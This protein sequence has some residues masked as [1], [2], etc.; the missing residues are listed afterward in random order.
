MAQLYDGGGASARQRCDCYNSLRFA[1]YTVYSM[2]GSPNFALLAAHCRERTREP[3]TA[4][5]NATVCNQKQQTQPTATRNNTQ[6]V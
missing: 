2:M 6:R 3:P 1:L 5:Q 4:L